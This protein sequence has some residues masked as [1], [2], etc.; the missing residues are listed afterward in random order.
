M[1][2][3]AGKELHVFGKERV[4][5]S[6]G[7]ER[8]R[9][10]ASQAPLPGKRGVACSCGG[11]W[12]GA[13]CCFSI[14][15]IKPTRKTED[16]SFSAKQEWMM[17]QST[18]RR[19]LRSLGSMLEPDRAALSLGCVSPHALRPPAGNHDTRGQCLQHSPVRCTTGGVSPLVEPRESTDLTR[20]PRR[21]GILIAVSIH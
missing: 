5:G 11:I 21:A 17:F 15:P 12:R 10:K 16:Y 13:R 6:G 20:I 19:C 4:V 8:E 2:G 3:R 7:R 18:C 1:S 14:K 9:E